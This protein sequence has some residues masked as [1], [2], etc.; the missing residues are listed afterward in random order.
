M[1]SVRHS[2]DSKTWWP[3]VQSI[4]Q[5]RE[6]YVN[7][8]TRIKLLREIVRNN[9][10]VRYTDIESILFSDAEKSHFNLVTTNDRKLESFA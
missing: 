7:E 8:N 1:W 6:P 10:Q 9:G 5:F 2:N 4:Y 3:S